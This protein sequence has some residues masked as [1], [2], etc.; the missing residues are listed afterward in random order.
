MF[1]LANT[2]PYSYVDTRPLNHIVARNQNGKIRKKNKK[3]KKK[4]KNLKIS[5]YHEAS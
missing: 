2:F 1:R 3:N 5:E 4:I